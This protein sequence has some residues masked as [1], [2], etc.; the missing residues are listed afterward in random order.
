MAASVW[1]GHITFGLVSLPVRLAV[2][3]RS[4]TIGFNQLHKTDNSRVKQVIFCQA[5]DKPIE[6]S[7]I[8]KG[9]EYEKGKYVVIDEEDIKKIQPKTAKVMEIL[10]FVKDDEVDAVYLESSYYIQPE[11]AGEKPYTLLYESLKRS[12]YV[13]IAKAT[14]HQREHIVIVRPGQHGLLLHTMYYQDEV[15]ALDE[16]R[17][18]TD[19]VKDKELLMAQSLIEAMAGTFDPSKYSDNFRST[20]K[21]MIEAKI[22]GEEVVA[23]PQAEEVKPVIDIMEALRTSLEALK[24]PPAASAEAASRTGGLFDVTAVDEPRKKTAGGGRRR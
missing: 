8:V 17:T 9:Y 13:G 16:F 7:E 5:E 11:E 21:A 14:M 22:A 20:V 24:K 6:R 15:R 4:E 19:A 10:E 23:A 1:K 2:A 18:N 12:G 3:A